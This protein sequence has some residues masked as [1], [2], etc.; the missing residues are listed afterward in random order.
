MSEHVRLTSQISLFYII[1]RPRYYSHY[2][3]KLDPHWGQN[4]KVYH[5]LIYGVLI[6]LTLIWKWIPF[7]TNNEDDNEASLLWEIMRLDYRQAEMLL[8]SIKTYRYLKIYKDWYSTCTVKCIV[9]VGFTVDNLNSY[10][11][12]HPW[13]QQSRT[14]ICMEILMKMWKRNKKDSRCINKEKWEVFLHKSGIMNL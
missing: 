1:M 10:T 7:L 11:T 8:V 13:Y 4:S 6:I 3:F 5:I 14:L 12:F 9:Q 2:F